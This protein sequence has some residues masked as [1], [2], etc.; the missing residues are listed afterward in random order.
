VTKADDIRK[1]INDKLGSDVV[2]L[3]SDPALAVSYLATG[4]LPID[5]LLG[6]GFPRGRFVEIYGDYSTLKSYIAMKAI[7]ETQKL[8]GVCVLNDTEHAYAPDWAE[9]LGVSMKDLIYLTPDDGEEAVDMAEVAVRDHQV[10][11]FVWDSIAAT[12]PQ[13]DSKKRMLG[14]NVQPGT[15]ASLMSNGL[16][17]INSG[18]RK[19]AF[20]FIN[21]TRLNI[22]M[23]FGD[24]TSIPGGKAMGFYASYRLSLKKVGKIREDVQTYEGGKKTTTKRTTGQKIKATVEKSKL[25]APFKDTTLLWDYDRA[26]LDEED[27]LIGVGMEKGL[28]TTNGKGSWDIGGKTMRSAAEKLPAKL[29]ESPELLD[30]VRV[31]LGMQEPVKKKAVKLKRKS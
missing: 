4:I 16:R 29:R 8:G 27:F 15:L 23:T 7:A 17:R 31:S 13:N 24:P 30:P 25:S 3:G 19:T 2:R 26:C 21:Q 9:S 18:N 11:L 10:D 14:E 22:G 28:I 1:E 5:L 20:C 12:K 6:G